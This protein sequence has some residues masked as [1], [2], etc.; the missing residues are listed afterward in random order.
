MELFLACVGGVALTALACA[1]VGYGLL[2]VIARA[3][4]APD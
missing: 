3:A 1:A 2:L 4:G